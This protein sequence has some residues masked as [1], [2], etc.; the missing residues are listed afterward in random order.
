MKS[1][2][3]ALVGLLILVVASFGFASLHYAFK[4]PSLETG[5]TYSIAIMTPATHP[6]L[7]EIEHG[8][9]DQLERSKNAS[10]TFTTFNGNG[11]RQLMR[12]QVEEALVG[13]YDLIFTIGGGLSALSKE[14]AEK[15]GRLKPIVCTAIADPFGLKLIKSIERSGTNAVCV[16]ELPNFDLHAKMLVAVKPEVKNILLVYD[17]T[18]GSGLET[19]RASLEL[20]LNKYGI[21]LRALPV[22]TA[23]EVYAKTA[24]MLG[25]AD[26]VMILKDHTTVSAVDGLIKI[27]S[28]RGIPLMASDLNSG[29]KGAALSFGI[30]EGD[31][32][33]VG[34]DFAS[35]ILEQGKKVEELASRPVVKM[36]LKI[37]ASTAKKQGLTLTDDQLLLFKH[38]TVVE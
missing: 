19:E 24:S 11:N 8:F 14:L 34:A 21:V 31:Y 10:Y 28:Q 17:P 4:V 5:K 36:Y 35:E 32:G 16:L 30:H 29:D 13:D 2:S 6:A 18:Q 12:A 26:M 37:N 33:I 38:I 25:N 15:K 20:A 3:N 9:R 22:S 1:Y 23:Q 27:C 7:Q